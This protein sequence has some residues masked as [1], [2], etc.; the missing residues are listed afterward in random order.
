MA[1][2][3]R[4]AA[5]IVAP[6]LTALAVLVVSSAVP[7]AAQPISDQL[8]TVRKDLEEREALA[9]ERDEQAASLMAEIRAIDGRLLR[10]G[11]SRNSLRSEEKR[12]EEEYELHLERIE[13]LRS[14]SQRARA[15]LSKRLSSIY[16]RGRLGNN[17]ALL[18]AAASSEPLRMARYL[19]AV[20]RSDTGALADYEA[21]SLRHEEA[22]RE[23]DAKKESI[24][25]KKAAFTD[26]QKR[27]EAA[28]IEKTQLLARIETDREVERLKQ[29]ELVA[30]EIELRE[31]LAASPQPD[32]SDDDLDEDEAAALDD[33]ETDEDG[34]AS[35]TP[36][37]DG[38]SKSVGNRGR[39]AF[40]AKANRS[41][42]R[43]T[44]TPFSERKGRL[45]APLHGEIVARYG[46][47]A[48]NGARSP[49]VVV[50]A[51]R[52]VQVI[53]IAR[54]EVVFSAPFPGLGNTIIINHGDRY[55]TVYA[56]L[57]VLQHEVG[58]RVRAN[59]IVGSVT[60]KEPL[61]H[62]ELRAEGK[63][64]DPSGW[65]DGGYS[66]FHP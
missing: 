31:I 18:Q 62:F 15:L 63:P 6:A 3:V 23:L 4:T 26:E 9:A 32:L 28:R 40:H 58:D 20:S 59:E 47:E 8:D 56:K 7:V 61:L 48:R 60:P 38:S 34:D 41:R 51:G 19:A 10:S 29:E 45:E 35:A 66:A 50:K 42:R 2:S 64:I 24:E 14:E 52:D 57:E 11:R 12:L 37:R 5:R 21:V 30:A 46:E 39:P 44:V 33:A 27:Y 17:R 43:A 55:H 36:A 13:L 54:G 65:L 1:L 53:S 25:A 16:K 22:I 49:G